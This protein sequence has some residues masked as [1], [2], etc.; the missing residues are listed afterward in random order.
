MNA[1]MPEP[2]VP[3]EQPL[4]ELFREVLDLADQTVD[5]VS[6]DDVE[7]RLQQL[8]T[9]QPAGKSRHGVDG[10]SGIWSQARQQRAE[11]LAAAQPDV[12][13]A[14]RHAS[15]SAQGQI[16]DAAPATVRLTHLGGH[17]RRLREAQALELEETA[18]RVGLTVTALKR[19]EAGKS[20]ARSGCLTSM[21]DIYGVQD[22]GQRQVLLEMARGG[23]QRDWWAVREDHMPAGFGLYVSLEAAAPSLRN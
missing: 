17:L 9:R 19:I 21:L 6:S 7:A 1:D 4:S 13:Q 2:G 14:A 16:G 11:R 22:R 18:Q 8:I 15:A 3:E 23:R 12:R 20:P 5:T 10:R